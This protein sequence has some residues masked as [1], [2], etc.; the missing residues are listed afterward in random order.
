MRL[1][2][3]FGRTLREAPASAELAA[4]KLAIRAG[5]VRSFAPG[6]YAYL[7]LG[8]RVLARLADLVEAQW[9]EL[10]GQR[11]RLPLVQPLEVWEQ[12]GRYPSLRSEMVRFRD[13]ANRE[14]IVGGGGE[15]PQ[16]ALAATEVTS[17][18]QLPLFLFDVALAATRSSRRRGFFGLASE[19][20]VAGYS[21]H[22]DEPDM[23]AFYDSVAAAIETVMGRCGVA[24]TRA[25]AA[26]A[27]DAE[28]RACR[29]L[30]PHRDGTDSYVRCQSCDYTAIQSTAQFA[31]PALETDELLPLQEVATPG[32]ETIAALAEYLDVPTHRTLKVVFYTARGHVV[33]VAIRGD[34]SVDERKLAHVLGDPDFYPSTETELAAVGTVG[35]YGSPLGLE[36]VRVI[37]DRTVVA[38]RNLVAGANKAGYHV[39]NVNAG[40]DFKVHH[41]ADLA[42]V[43]DGD[44][45]ASCAGTLELKSGFALAR[46]EMMGSGLSEAL[47]ATYL[48]ANGVAQP[49]W[50][51][52]YDIGLDRL[53]GSVIETGHDEQGIVWPVVCAPYHVHLLA[54]NLNKPEIV[55]QAEALYEQLRGLGTDVLYD[56]R[57]LSAG[58]KFNDAD[59]IGLPLRV[60]VSSRSLQQGGVEVKWRDESDRKV[61][62]LDEL[63]DEVKQRGPEL[64]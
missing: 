58:V 35:G 24:A 50:L 39:L 30:L 41:V 12:S 26:V 64:G 31:E 17:H 49:L 1:S 43:E 25:D 13:E 55:E 45:C 22:V 62:P 21:L 56:D 6:A 15:E 28:L 16:L 10:G 42:R 2:H 51:A 38:A 14:L 19:H 27:G 33:C 32:A 57:D 52:A 47:D 63:P 18:G 61:I 5:L 3:Q 37:A 23:A 8:W 11:M 20:V 36:G 29:W 44:P 34:R 59:L 46:A 53:L 9:T 4:D 40:R 7:P 54:L 48:D 60:T